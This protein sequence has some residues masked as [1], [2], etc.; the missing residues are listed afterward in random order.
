MRA[1]VCVACVI[2]CL[3]VVVWLLSYVTPARA[4]A[5]ALVLLITPVLPVLITD[6]WRVDKMKEK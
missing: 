3:K 5:A 4:I 6:P 1:L 2:V